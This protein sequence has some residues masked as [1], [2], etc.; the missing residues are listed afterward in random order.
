[1]KKGSKSRSH[2]FECSSF[3]LLRLY[4]PWWLQIYVEAYLLN[5]ITSKMMIFSILASC[6]WVN[7]TSLYWEEETIRAW[8]FLSLCKPANVS[9][10]LSSIDVGI[11]RQTGHVGSWS[12][13]EDNLLPSCG[14]PG[15]KAASPSHTSLQYPFSL[16]CKLWNHFVPF[17][18]YAQCQDGFL[19]SGYSRWSSSP[20]QR[21]NFRPVFRLDS[22]PG[23]QSVSFSLST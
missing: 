10:L 4:G 20:A 13:F 3:L 15:T 17:V 9:L 14:P 19:I 12:L 5:H 1:M 23:L 7:S 21:H 11:W 2:L 6:K 8:I 18:W 16:H 22:I